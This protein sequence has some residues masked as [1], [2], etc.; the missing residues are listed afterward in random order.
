MGGTQL[1][2]DYHNISNYAEK[3]KAQLKDFVLRL[4][5]SAVART[6]TDFYTLLTSVEFHY[7]NYFS[8]CVLSI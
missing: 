3:P 1:S 4:T 8:P 2:A 5:C 6:L 7:S